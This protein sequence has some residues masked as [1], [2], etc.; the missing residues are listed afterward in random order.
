MCG[1][2]YECDL[3]NDYYVLT[4]TRYGYV[5]DYHYDYVFDYELVWLDC[6]YCSCYAP[7]IENVIWIVTDVFPGP[8]KQQCLY[9]T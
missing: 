3:V 5:H 2:H 4:L 9:R 6:Y 8:V 1:T 7:E